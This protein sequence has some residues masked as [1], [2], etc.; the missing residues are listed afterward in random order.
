MP[1]ELRSFYYAWE[2]PVLETWTPALEQRQTDLRIAASLKRAEARVAAYASG[3][4]Q[5][6]VPNHR[7]VAEAV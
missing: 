4:I 7:P 5:T 6:S 3:A 2:K 1:E